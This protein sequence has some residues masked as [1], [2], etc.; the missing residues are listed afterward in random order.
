M[1]G[2]RLSQ[3]QRERILQTQERRR[4]RLNER[5]ARH[6][7]TLGDG[8]LGAEQSGLVIA[9]YGATL[10]VE[11]SEGELYRCAV[12]QHLGLPVCGDR[13]IWQTAG[14]GQGVVSAVEP[15]RSLLS[16]PDYSGRPKPMAANIDQVAVVLAPRPAWQEQLIDA[17]LV[18]IATLEVTPL[19]VA[20]KM[21]LLAAAGRRELETR[22]AVYQRLGY[23][24][25]FASTCSAPGLDAL[26]ARLA[27]R[28]SILV[29]QSGVG[30]SSLV[31]TLLPDRDIRIRDLSQATGL[32]AHATSTA[33]LYHLPFG[34]ALIDSPGVRSFTPLALET[35]DLE[36]GFIEFLPYRG[37]CR[38]S[39]CSHTTE[40]GCALLAAVAQGAIDPQ[41]LHSYYHLRKTLQSG[42]SKPFRGQ[43]SRERQFPL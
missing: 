35:A 21:D 40:P 20:N 13:V 42:R 27:G 10:I 38:F 39:D 8:S 22:L 9:N 32:G 29:G 24:I 2:R 7:Y 33:T 25:L 16:R 37:Q 34:G 12:R 26:C 23:P 1:A 28:T 14:P 6:T 4:Q 30:K 19:L 11:D 43:Q 17:Y 41:R 18:T 36:R 15:R 3:H 31:K 5:I